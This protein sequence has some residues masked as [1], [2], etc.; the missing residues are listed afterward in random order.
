[1][2][3]WSTAAPKQ[4]LAD[5][6]L[7][8]HVLLLLLHQDRC[9]PDAAEH[10]LR[11]N[12]GKALTTQHKTTVLIIGFPPRS[13]S[14]CGH[15]QPS[16]VGWGRA[17]RGGVG[18]GMAVSWHRV[19]VRHQGRAA[20][21]SKR[22]YYLFLTGGTSS[23]RDEVTYSRPKSPARNRTRLL[24]PAFLIPEGNPC[25]TKEGEEES[26]GLFLMSSFWNS[27]IIAL[28]EGLL[29]MIWWPSHFFQ[30]YFLSSSLNHMM[31]CLTFHIHSFSN[32]NKSNNS[33]PRFPPLTIYT[34]T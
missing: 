27:M 15:C 28:G 1:M 22:K 34:N 10:Q 16:G 7:P 23:W 32:N 4:E 26:K 8:L 2:Q 30:C 21:L 6:Q 18:N 25:E 29:W 19:T 14:L 24:Q 17:A 5:A 11:R 33:I 31:F 9:T 3:F 20:A 13:G 12:T